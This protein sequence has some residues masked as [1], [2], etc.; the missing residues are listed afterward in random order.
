LGT[1]VVL[2]P[3]FSRG[4]LVKEGRKEVYTFVL[5]MGDVGKRGRRGSSRQ[6]NCVQV[7]QVVAYTYL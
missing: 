2:H 6:H 7:C 4:E 3:N 1:V 5:T